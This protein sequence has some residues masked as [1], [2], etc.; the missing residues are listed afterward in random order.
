M[1][2]TG[3]APAQPVVFCVDDDPKVL[4]W[5]SL[6]L[7]NGDY[8]V[9]TESSALKALERIT[10]E[11]PDLVLL[12]ASMPDLDGYEICRTLQKRPE[13]AYVPVVFVTARTGEEDRA[14]AFS[15]G[16]ADVLAKPVKADFLLQ[17]V[18]AHIATKRKFEEIRKLA[19]A[20]PEEPDAPVAPSRW[21]AK[22]NSA[23]FNRFRDELLAKLKVSPERAKAFVKLG[24]AGLYSGTVELGADPRDVS[25]S[26]AAFLG[27]P[28]VTELSTR[29]VRTGVLPAAFCA[30]NQILAVKGNSD[31]PSFVLSNPFN[32]EVLE[33]LRRAT[34][35]GKPPELSIAAPAVLTSLG[36]AP[37]PG[38]PKPSSMSEIQAEL[39]RELELLVETTDPNDRSSVEAGP[40][41]ELVHR[42]I[43]TGFESGASDVHIEPAE[44]E[45]I[46]RYR[47]DGDL[48]IVNRLTPTAVAKRI[49]ARLKVMSGLDLAEHRLPQDGRIRF[50][51]YSRNDHDF[52]LRVAILP[53]QHGEKACLRIIDKQKSV[54]PLEKLG[55]SPSNLKLYREKI[56]APYGLIL[57]VGP[58]G[59]GKSMSL[60]AA[61]NEIKSPAIN[62]HTA[63]DPIEYTLPGINQV[64]VNADIGF[65][66]ARALRSFLRM[67]PDVI[68]VGEIRDQETAKIAIEAS[69]TG[70]VVFS[71]LHTNDAP[72]TVTRFIEMGIDP[73]LVS[74]SLVLIC[75]QRLVKRICG[76]CKESYPPTPE[77][78]R[79]LGIRP[80]A[81]AKLWRGKGCGRCNNAGTRGRMAI[82]EILSPNDAV[83]R[84]INEPGVS[85]EILKK[86]ARKEVGMRTLWEDSV[87]KILGGLCSLKDVLGNVAP[88]E[89]PT[90]GGG[91]RLLSEEQSA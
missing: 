34:E 29:D 9:L 40:L 3:D 30:Q 22:L 39:K 76:D 53:I 54:L 50:K 24:P 52:D 15:A 18:A 66:F 87:E 20:P 27:L 23:G 41:V 89:V 7:G 21:D 32:W 71:T 73:Y 68:L 13:T 75:A 5:M 88:D 84:A 59:S 43:E 42:L 10:A 12:D 85:A 47:I 72:A 11:P 16:A 37:K 4:A 67:D 57:H 6:T 49:I 25:A 79:V 55:F 17:T 1:T 51:Q 60:Y 90:E 46:V 14:E 38:A 65:T 82:H 45:V 70:H 48:Q 64:Q 61:L 62:I 77:E 86:V 81:P 83:R 31:A 2:M 91:P 56:E 33:A 44:H 74:S 19:E 69:L 35:H 26:L 80:G 36:S 78:R 58:T 8:F 28:H 63:E